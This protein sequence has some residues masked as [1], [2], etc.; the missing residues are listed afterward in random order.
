MQQS[1][2]TDYDLWSLLDATCFVI[3]RLRRIELARVGLTIEQSA[4]LDL[5]SR[6]HGMTTAK[7]IERV[8]MRQ[9]HTVSVLVNRMAKRDLL[10]KQTSP[11]HKG[12]IILLTENGSQLFEGMPTGSIEAVFGAFKIAERNR[13]ASSLHK[14]HLRARELLGGPDA[15]PFVRRLKASN[16]SGPSEDVQEDRVPSE[17][18]LWSLLQ[19]T[20][21]SVARLRELE[22]NEFGL[23]IEQASVLRILKDK[24]ALSSKEL[25]GLTLRRHNSMSIL[26]TRMAQIGLVKKSRRGS[27]KANRILITDSG[28]ELLSKVTFAAV[29]MAFSVLTSVEREKLTASLCF[30]NARAR[31]LLGTI[32]PAG[33]MARRR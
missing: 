24:G 22:L 5:L 3:S 14:V 16:E 6:R 11:S 2:P 30:L 32:E 25:E 20:R 18:R 7:E 33:K 21:F 28:S 10:R 12:N 15:I 27:E 9:H 19:A 26:T 17:Y 1:S 31:G 4:I 8:T 29:P 13:F 23:T